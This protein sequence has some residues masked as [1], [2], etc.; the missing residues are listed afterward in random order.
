MRRARFLLLAALAS[1]ALVLVA[2]AG[3]EDATASPAPSEA[4]PSSMATATSIPSSTSTA[5]PVPSTP[6]EPPA[7]PPIALGQPFTLRIGE[8]VTLGDGWRI[9]LEGVTEDSRCPTDVQ[10]VWAGQVKVVLS[11]EGASAVESIEAVMPA[12]G[13]VEAGLD[14]HVVELVG[15]EP[16]PVSTRPIADEEYVLALLVRDASGAAH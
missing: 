10:C 13:P 4:S 16:A 14:G 12:G 1:I 15:L 7:S 9:G 3:N 2:C 8:R 5:S 11:V 6:S